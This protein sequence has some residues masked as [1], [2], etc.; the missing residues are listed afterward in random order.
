VTTAS[1]SRPYYLPEGLAAPAPAPDGLGAEYW[2]G[3]REHK[4]RVQRCADCQ[5]WQWGPEWICHNCH[6]FN[7]DW[8]EV[9]P[10]GRIYSWERCWYPVH[11]A[12]REAGPYIV[13]LVELPH[14]GNIRMVGNLLGDPEQEVVIG[15]D[16]E[17]VFEDHD[18][19]DPPYTLVHW[20]TT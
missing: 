7:L 18:T 12:L 4:V 16:V 10:R 15:S 2:E 3:V 1:E 8:V 9:E 20:Q 14:A 5:T 11:P 6:S 13:V 17:A 19:A